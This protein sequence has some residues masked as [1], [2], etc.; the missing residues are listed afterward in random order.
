VP[1]TALQQRT[2]TI[3][4]LG[5]TSRCGSSNL[6]EGSPS[7]Q[8]APS[9]RKRSSFRKSN[10]AGR[11][12]PPL[13]FGL[14][15]RGVCH[16]GDITAAAVGSYPTFSPLPAREPCR[17]PEGFPPVCHRVTLR[18]RYLLCGTF[19]EPSQPGR[20]RSPGVT[21]R[22]YPEAH[23]RRIALPSIGP[24]SLSRSGVRTFLPSRFVGAALCRL[25]SPEPA[26]V[27]LT[28]QLHCTKGFKRNLVLAGTRFFN[29]SGGTSPEHPQNPAWDVRKLPAADQR[30]QSQGWT[31]AL[32]RE[33]CC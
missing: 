1:R 13:L 18:R 2:A 12:S 33:Y 3:I 25:S 28:R 16:A 8:L 27:R 23:G 17:H 4:P 30:F 7:K 26:I 21:R 15:P 19:R 9:G 20:G 32:P 10:S 29:G 6:P 31:T 14:A 11:A 5:R 22:V 24:S